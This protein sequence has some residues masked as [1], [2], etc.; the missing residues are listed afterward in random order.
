MANNGVVTVD[1]IAENGEEGDSAPN[2]NPSVH[3]TSVHGPIGPSVDEGRVPTQGTYDTQPKTSV[4]NRLSMPNGNELQFR[5]VT[6]LQHQNGTKESYASKLQSNGPNT[7][8][9]LTFF[10]L[11]DKGDIL[12]IDVWAVGELKRELQVAVPSLYGGKETVVT[13]QVDYLWESSQCS[14]CKVFGH[15]ISSCV[16][17]TVEKQKSKGKN[18]TRGEV[19][20]DGFTLVTNKK[21]LA[22]NNAK[23]VWI[24][25]VVQKDVGSTSGIVKDKE[26]IMGANPEQAVVQSA[27]GIETEMACDATMAQ[28]VEN[29]APRGKRESDKLKDAT[30]NFSTLEPMVEGTKHTADLSAPPLGGA[31]HDPTTGDFLDS[32]RKAFTNTKA[33]RGQFN[34]TPFSI[35][36]D[37]DEE[38]SDLHGLH[39]DDEVG[40]TTVDVETQVPGESGTP[41]NVSS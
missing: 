30:S 11:S 31:V 15:K 9:S 21:K 19:D 12:L 13:V 2:P 39:G 26:T 28:G 20:A 36:M 5:N 35:L 23:H 17:T 27:P 33:K 34:T 41:P 38:E 6:I 10:P 37:L 4:F 40:N 1:P 29:E 22:Q 18:Q 14:H 24:H 7:D 8:N 32:V 3:A 25:K 16:K